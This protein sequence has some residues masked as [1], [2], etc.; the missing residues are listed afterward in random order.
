M[1]K[2]IRI[3]HQVEIDGWEIR[4]IG[5]K[6]STGNKI[7][8]IHIKIEKITLGTSCYL[9]KIKYHSNHCNKPLLVDW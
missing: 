2:Q 7:G 6:I 5:K 4:V 1:A 9:T 8:E 3:V